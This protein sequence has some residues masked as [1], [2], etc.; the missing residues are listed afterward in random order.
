M[1]VEEAIWIPLYYS[2]LSSCYS[3]LKRDYAA[4]ACGSRAMDVIL[5][6]M[7][8]GHVLN[9]PYRNVVIMIEDMEA[10]LTCVWKRHMAR[11][12]EEWAKDEDL[13]AIPGKTGGYCCRIRGG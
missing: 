10:S 6:M 3:S 5:E 7:K 8:A 1:E 2:L 13:E 12:I 11:I 4:W 9:G